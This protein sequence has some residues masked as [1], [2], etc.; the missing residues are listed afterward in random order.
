MGETVSVNIRVD[1]DTKKDV[2]KLFDNLGLNM[3]SA[4]NI[5]LKQ[6]LNSNGIPFTIQVPDQHEDDGILEL[7]KYGS[8][9]R[10][11]CLN[12]NFKRAIPLI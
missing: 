2:E 4:V 9:V 11:I 1:K 8:V 3:S 5:F 10:R 6:C 12:M 7:Y